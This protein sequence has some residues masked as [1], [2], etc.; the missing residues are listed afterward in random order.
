MLYTQVVTNS[1]KIFPLSRKEIEK[2]IKNSL[3][4]THTHLVSK[5]TS[6]VVKQSH[7]FLEGYWVALSQEI[8]DPYKEEDLKELLISHAVQ[9]TLSKLID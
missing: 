8:Q 3:R 1:L 9:Y 2:G 5:V 7:G 4:Y 6:D